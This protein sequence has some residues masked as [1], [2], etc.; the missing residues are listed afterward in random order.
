V[1]PL[2]RVA[3]DMWSMEYAERSDVSLCMSNTELLQ[4]R[5]EKDD[6]FKHADQSPVPPNKRSGFG[7]LVYF[8]PN[9]D[10]VFEVTLEE[11]EPTDITIHTTTGEE[12]TYVRT[13]KAK[14]VVEGEDATVALYSTGHE[15]LF[16]P[17]KDATSG[18]ETYGA[19]RYVDVRPNGDGTA[20]IDFN[21]SY[22]PFCAYNDRY[23]C[24]LPPAENWLSVAIRAGERNPA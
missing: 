14:I 12:R 18:A 5:K 16:L 20:V 3:P 11:I 24:A 15:G 22:A 17:F 23:S 4:F 9:D 7:E 6:F 8:E 10:L 2:D 19:G 1:T 21:Y 13:A